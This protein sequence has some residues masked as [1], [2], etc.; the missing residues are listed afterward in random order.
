MKDSDRKI[1]NNWKI[2][3][4]KEIEYRGFT[5]IPNFEYGGKGSKPKFVCGN[6]I[7]K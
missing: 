7:N 6:G 5:T 4:Q 3:K 1:K 2:L